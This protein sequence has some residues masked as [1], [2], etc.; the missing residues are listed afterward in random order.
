MRDAKTH[1]ARWITETS[2]EILCVCVCVCACMSMVCA[3][4]R[5]CCPHI[6]HNINRF[7]H[8]CTGTGSFSRSLNVAANS[9][10]KKNWDFNKKSLSVMTYFHPSNLAWKAA[11]RAAGPL[12]KLA[13][14][15]SSVA[16]KEVDSS[17][18]LVSLIQ[19][20]TL[21]IREELKAGGVL[22]GVGRAHITICVEDKW[23]VWAT[24]CRRVEIMIW[25]FGLNEVPDSKMS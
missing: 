4:A 11:G 24:H 16:G 13:S 25:H 23:Q 6:I 17:V 1:Q 15:R 21:K 18:R 9:G 19:S 14:Q 12:I 8:Q 5:V 20:L 2:T 3:Y 22:G 7:V 10:W